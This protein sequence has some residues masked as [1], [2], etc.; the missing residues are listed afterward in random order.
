MSVQPPGP[1]GFPLNGTVSA[2]GAQLAYTVDG[3]APNCDVTESVVVTDLKA[4]RATTLAPPASTSAMFVAGLWFGDGGRMFA[5]YVPGPVPCAPGKA[6]PPDT[7]TRVTSAAV[8]ERHGST[9]KAVGRPARDGAE[10]GNGRRLELTGTVT[11][12]PRGIE[13]STGA[14]LRLIGDGNPRT[15]SKNVTTFAVAPN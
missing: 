13:R 11:V 12:N 1:T 5:A 3:A 10:L 9:W 4:G 7:P 14:T 2:D 8:Y 6:E 15:I